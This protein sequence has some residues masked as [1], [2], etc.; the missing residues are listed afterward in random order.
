MH[1]GQTLVHVLTHHGFY[2][3]L[4]DHRFLHQNHGVRRVLCRNDYRQKKT[5]RGA[6]GGRA[7]EQPASPKQKRHVLFDIHLA[8]DFHFYLALLAFA[9]AAS[10]RAHRSPLVLRDKTRPG[11]SISRVLPPCTGGCLNA[12]TVS[13]RTVPRTLPEPSS[14][15]LSLG[16]QPNEPSLCGQS[17]TFPIR[18]GVNT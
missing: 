3:G 4:R 1:A 16:A 12:E 18:I 7:D 17:G 14:A 2:I 10:G 11:I 15:G 9:D 13:G 6:Q 5:S 8:A